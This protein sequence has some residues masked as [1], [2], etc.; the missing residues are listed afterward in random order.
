MS[1]GDGVRHAVV[2]RKRPKVPF[3]GVPSAGRGEEKSLGHVFECVWELEKSCELGTSLV[4]STVRP[5]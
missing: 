1:P 2:P 3:G 5:Q 4:M